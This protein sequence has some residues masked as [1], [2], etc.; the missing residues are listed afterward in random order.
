MR[1]GAGIG[2]RTLLAAGSALAAPVLAPSGTARAQQRGD[3]LTIAVGGAFS[4]MDPHFHALTPN[5]A[6]AQ[7]I[8]D[9]LV[10]HD[11][12]FRPYPALAESWRPVTETT[13]EFKL[14]RGVNWHDGSPFT[15]DDVVFTFE[16]VPQ[17]RNSPSNFTI[18]TRP[19]QRLEVVDSHTIRMHTAAPNPLVPTLMGGLTL[20]SRK[21][22]QGAETADFNSGKATVGT[23]PYRMVSY[24]PGDRVVFE[25]NDAWWGPAQPWRRVV[26]RMI[27][28]EATRI[29]ALSAGDVDVIDSVPT[30]DVGALQSNNRLTIVSQAG[31]RNIYLFLDHQRDDTPD[32]SGPNGEKLERSPLKDVRVRRALSL[33]INREGIVQQIMSGFAAPSGQ[34]LS[35]GVF[36]HDPSIQHDPYDPEAA[37]RLLTEAGYPN[38]FRIKL[39]GPNDRYVNDERIVQAIAQ[40]W[41]RVGVRTEV[42]VMPSNVFF[43]RSARNEFSIGLL[44]WGTGTGEPDSPMSALIATANRDRGRGVANR[45]LYSN[46]AFDALLDRAL[47]TID[48]AAREKVYHEATRLVMPDYPII[49]LHH[50]VNIWA[51]RRGLRV[52]PRNDERTLAME[53]APVNA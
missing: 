22:A 35:R 16:R 21:H 12:N 3:T 44:G 23:G 52:T 45:S 28:N 36:G 26:Y 29:A 4:S 13:W 27:T 38:G 20:I 2:R 53:I 49:P 17:V 15:A 30:R 42:N 25:R 31:L 34:F 43:A 32:V 1:N 39:S 19:I 46:P 41:S 5:G 8:F 11:E 9:R 33:A 10:H 18:Y 48:D 37:K 6:V 40:M 47:A 51:S 24:M 7:H 14:R 50:Q